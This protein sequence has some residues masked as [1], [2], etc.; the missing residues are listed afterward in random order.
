MGKCLLACVHVCVYT[1]TYITYV[2]MG[3]WRVRVEVWGLSHV[4]CGWGMYGSWYVHVDVWVCRGVGGLCVVGG[5]CQFIHFQQKQQILKFTHYSPSWNYWICKQQ[6]QKNV[7]EKFLTALTEFLGWEET[8]SGIYQ[9]LQAEETELKFWGDWESQSTI[10]DGDD[11]RRTCP[12][13]RT[14]F[15]L[16][17]T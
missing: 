9:V 10:K 13:Q 4:K 15:L 1:H 6:K 5:R 2:Q 3:Q 7:S 16:Y 11:R 8:K 12:F 17:P 14:L